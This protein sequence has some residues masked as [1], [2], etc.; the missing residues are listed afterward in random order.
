[1]PYRPLFAM[2]FAFAVGGVPAAT[3]AQQVSVTVNGQP[4]YL[5]PGPIERAGRVFVPLRGIFERLGAGVV[6]SAGTINA[7]KESTTVSLHI[8]S[9]QATVNG[10]VQYLD[11]APFIVGATTYVPLRFV[12]QALGA[13][14]GYDQSTQVVAIVVERPVVIAPPRPPPPPMRPNPPPNPPPAVRLRAQQPAPDSETRDRFIVISAEFTRNVDAGS[15]RVWLD[16]ANVTSRCGISSTAFSYKPPAPLD[17]GSH[18][19]RVAGRGPGGATFDHSWSFSVRRST[20]PAMTLTIYQP[21]P[22]APVDRTFSVQ[23]NTVANASVRVTAGASP[24]STGQFNGTTVAGPKGNF[25][26]QVTLRSMPG[27]QAVT[28]RITATDPVSSQ[29]TETVLQLRLNQ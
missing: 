14:V 2:F 10:Q 13:N 19:M 17:F 22:N 8:G 11:V 26:L 25:K 4:L 29:S 21:A 7:T 18:T 15:V 16:G 1:M 12:A 20:P 27:Q 23:G 3:V 6:Y 28:V 5:N 24:S 9:T